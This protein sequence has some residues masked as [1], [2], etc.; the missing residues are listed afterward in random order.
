[1]SHFQRKKKNCPES[2]AYLP[3]LAA[4]PSPNCR[5]Q[6][7]NSIFSGIISAGREGHPGDAQ[8][9]GGRGWRGETRESSDV[10]VGKGSGSREK[11][12]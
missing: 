10:A 4:N 2:V 9:Y 1:M 3:K 6:T 8:T 11:M 12:G 7:V 5:Q